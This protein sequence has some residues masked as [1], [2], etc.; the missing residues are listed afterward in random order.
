VLQIRGF[1]K[2]EHVLAYG[3]ITLLFILSLRTS[4]A[5]LSA[6]FLFLAI[7]GVAAVDELT[8]PIVHRT[9]SLADWL[10][11]TAGVLVVFAFKAVQSFSNH[12][13][14]KTTDQTTISEN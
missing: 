13:Q 7:L 4:A 5:L 9:A 12:R 1:D 6:L 10:A 11:D 2:L 8:Q 14:A 3:A